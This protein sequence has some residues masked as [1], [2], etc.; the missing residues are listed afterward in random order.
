M[1]VVKLVLMWIFQ[2]AR[3]GFICITLLTALAILK[4][5]KNKR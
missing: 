3:L 4:D 1:E 5:W 2:L